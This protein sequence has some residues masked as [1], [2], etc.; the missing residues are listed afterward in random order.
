MSACLRILSSVPSFLLSFQGSSPE[1]FATSGSDGHCRVWDMRTGRD[2]DCCWSPL[3]LVHP[4]S[5]ASRGGV[6]ELNSDF[7]LTH[8]I[9]VNHEVTQIDPQCNVGFLNLSVPV[10]TCQVMWSLTGT[11]IKGLPP[12]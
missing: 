12:V 6:L 4:N 11:A 10:C 8:H 1:L 2:S 5:M 3:H 9:E 7:A